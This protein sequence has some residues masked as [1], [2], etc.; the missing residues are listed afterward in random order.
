[1]QQN[2]CGLWFKNLFCILSKNKMLKYVFLR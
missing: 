2:I 1:M